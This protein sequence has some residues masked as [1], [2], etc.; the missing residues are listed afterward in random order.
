M[1]REFSNKIR[2]IKKIEKEQQELLL[3]GDGEQ[4]LREGRQN[5]QNP[6]QALYDYNPYQPI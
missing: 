2:S 6:F 1:I 4:R 3:G 5:V